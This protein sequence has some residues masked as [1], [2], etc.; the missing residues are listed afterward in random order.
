LLIIFSKLKIVNDRQ[1]YHHV[2]D[3]I[4]IAKHL[5]YFY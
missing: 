5:S 3:N 2:S 4:F 1:S